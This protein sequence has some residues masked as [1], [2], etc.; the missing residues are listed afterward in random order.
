MDSRHYRKLIGALFL[1]ATP[2]A[3]AP[4]SLAQY[5]ATP[6]ATTEQRLAVQIGNLV[7][8]NAAESAQIE[9]LQH[10]VQD[11]QQQLQANAVPPVAPAPTVTPPPPAPPSSG[12]PV[13]PAIEP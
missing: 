10:Q 1:I 11:L 13:A 8:Q 7:I 3:A 6:P 12:P 5:Q 2:A 4:Q 9:M